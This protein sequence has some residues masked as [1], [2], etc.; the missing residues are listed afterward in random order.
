MVYKRVHNLPDKKFPSMAHRNENSKTCKIIIL[1]QNMF[2][3]ANIFV[4]Y[5][6]VKT[7]GL[8]ATVNHLLTQPSLA[9]LKCFTQRA[10][11]SL[12]LALSWLA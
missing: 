9:K 6:Q 4:C 11:T 2:T 10:K 8:P 1:T 3:T 7:I 5:G 12:K